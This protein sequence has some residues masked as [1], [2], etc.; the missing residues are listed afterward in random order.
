MMAKGQMEILGLAV[1]I[2]LAIMG[3]VFYLTFSS[4]EGVDRTTIEN[5]NNADS[6]DAILKTTVACGSDVTSPRFQLIELIKDCHDVPKERMCLGSC[7][8]MDSGIEK[9]L[10]KTLDKW[11]KRYHLSISKKE[12]GDTQYVIKRR[13]HDADNAFGT[14]HFCGSDS[15]AGISSTQPIRTSNGIELMVELKVCG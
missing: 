6:L 10:E 13:Y 8:H 3:L 14:Q 12:R 9:M 5:R 2:I 7:S 11:G 15:V 1:V 4:D